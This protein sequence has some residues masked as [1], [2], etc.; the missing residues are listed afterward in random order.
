MA[1][2]HKNTTKTLLVV[3]NDEILQCLLYKYLTLHQFST[4][5]MSNGSGLPLLLAKNRIDLIVMDVLLPDKSGLYWLKWL[6]QYHV[7]I[8]VI[9]AS[10]KAN[11]DD[12]L[13][14][15]ENGAKDY[16]MKPF[17]CKELLIRIENILT[18]HSYADNDN[19]YL[20]MGEL[21]L[22]TETGTVT[23]GDDH[24]KLT[25]LETD[26]LK[27]LYIN[28][29]SIISRDDIMGQ[30]RGTIHNPLDRSIDI[31]INK[32]RN[33][34]EDNP[35]EPTYIR[36]VRGKGYRLHIPEWLS[37]DDAI[38]RDN[39]QYAVSVLVN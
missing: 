12:R 20:H 26:I 10:V 37:T 2:V 4:R 19:R 15:L 36:T 16:L 23:K 5:F 17:Q 33:K 32:L 28:T 11:E 18:A 14:G 13:L 8:P 31:H 21:T 22:D 29:G 3:D 30:I 7:H 25:Q 1:I 27:L 39:L 9:I 35:A 24:V 6:R 38:K 34:I